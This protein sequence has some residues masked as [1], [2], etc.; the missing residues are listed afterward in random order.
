MEDKSNPKLLKKEIENQGISK[1][2][3]LIKIPLEIIQSSKS[4]CK[5]DTKE[6]IASGF[7]IKLF[8]GEEDFYCLMTNEHIITKKLIRQK[9]LIDIY[10]DNESKLKIIQLNPEERFIKEFTEDINID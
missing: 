1:D 8:K 4:I 3:P 6:K 10:Y 9:K 7:L 5:I 2:F